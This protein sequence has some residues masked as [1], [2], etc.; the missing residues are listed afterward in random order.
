MES[1]N[2]TTKKRRYEEVLSFDGCNLLYFLLAMGPTDVDTTQCLQDR[3]AYLAHLIPT[4]S[5]RPMTYLPTSDRRS[6][7]L[8]VQSS[9]LNSK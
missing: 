5:T 9:Q 6:R 2:S 7:P 3:P 8:K 4:A 1:L